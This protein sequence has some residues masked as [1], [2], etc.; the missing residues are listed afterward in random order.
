MLI[1][2]YLFNSKWSIKNREL[3]NINTLFSTYADLRFLNC[4]M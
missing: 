3:I 4:E 1:H 2:S